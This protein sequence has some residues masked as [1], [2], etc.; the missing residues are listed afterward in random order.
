MI[1]AEW[2]VMPCW[3]I[4]CAL[5]LAIVDRYEAGLEGPW[6]S[7]ERHGHEGTCQAP[8]A[9]SC[10]GCA[11]VD[12]L[13]PQPPLEL[14]LTHIEGRPRTHAAPA[15]GHEVEAL[16]PSRAADAAAAHGTPEDVAVQ[17][18]RLIELQAMLPM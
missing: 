13:Y 6:R 5:T 12:L 18:Q 16:V 4:L 11:T 10:L 7:H 15:P 1:P 17:V 2:A 3:D 8:P 9:S 14:S